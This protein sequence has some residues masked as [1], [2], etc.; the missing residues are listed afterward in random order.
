MAKQV[1]ITDELHEALSAQRSDTGVPLPIGAT[2]ERAVQL[3]L[4]QRRLNA[5]IMK[6]Y[7]ALTLDAARDVLKQEV[8]VFLGIPE[9][10]LFSD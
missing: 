9:E 6:A 8:A 3:Y 10:Y 1:K 5:L 7:Q 2:A 4:S